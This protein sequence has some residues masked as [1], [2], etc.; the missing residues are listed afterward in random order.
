M[1]IGA[2][3][4]V[5][6]SVETGRRPRG[7]V[8]NKT[9]SIPS[10]GGEH[11][12]SN[13][14]FH[15]EKLK[16]ID[17]KFFRTLKTGVI[18]KHTILIVK[19]GSTTGKT[20]YVGDDFPFEEAAVNEHVF[21]LKIDS[22]L[23]DS[24]YV[25]NF[26]KSPRGQREILKD[27]RGAAISGISKRFI[28]RVEIPLPPIQDQMRAAHLLDVVYELILQRKR[29]L[30]ELETFLKSVFL[31]MFGDPIKNEKGWVIS[32]LSD[33]LIQIDSGTSPKCE[34][35]PA[36]MN[37]WGVLKLG[38]ITSCLYD[39]KEN[40]ALPAVFTPKQRDEVKAGDLLFSRKN[41]YDLVAACAF[42]FE[43]RP[44]LLMPDLIFRLVFRKDAAINPIYI[45]KL[46]TNSR[47]RNKIQSHASGAAGSMP[48]ISKAS[49]NTI[50]LPIPPL[51]L[52]DKFS[53]IVT[54]VESVKSDYKRSILDLENLYAALS[55][56]AF[57]G[58]LD[59][60][61]IPLAAAR[62]EA[63]VETV[64]PTVS[65]STTHSTIHLPEIDFLLS[66][67]EDRNK[68]EGLLG[69]WLDA[70]HI[71]LAGGIFD[72]SQFYSAAQSRLSEVHSENEFELGNE[73]YDHIKN[74]VFD[75]LAKG[76]LCQEYNEETNRIQ[77]LATQI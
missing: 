45:W 69:T 44:R 43:T 40:K 74:W 61:K 11:L 54:K 47:Q 66:G 41:T 71:Q 17:E 37:E 22:S 60:S 76:K 58:K 38:S 39:E 52:Q 21:A 53:A 55:E 8:S 30:K 25:F 27:L 9:G 32:T 12:N 14:G 2:L 29:Q 6:S 28:D 15:L 64:L 49:L 73:G 13:G 7:G 24:R 77:L 51:P 19:D 4:T 62:P 10:L 16:F 57:K 75:A 63:K 33:L 31:Q 48:N 67:W 5:V 50:E 26:L 34:V 68:I 20:S 18:K 23:A 59:L 56:Q 46:L 42:V 72:A 36:A 1:K 65:M 3:S 35:R 70:Y